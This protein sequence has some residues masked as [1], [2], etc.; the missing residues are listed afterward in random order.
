LKRDLRGT[1][2][3]NDRLKAVLDEL[4]TMLFMVRTTAPDGQKAALIVP[5]IAYRIEHLEED[6]QARIWWEFSEAARNV[7]RSSESYAAI[8]RGILLAFDSRYAVTLYELGC[9][10][11]GRR[12]P[13]WE[14]TVE[15]LREVMGV[16][17]GK[18]RDWTGIRQ[19]VL[20]PACAEVNQIALFDVSYRTI[21]GL[22]RKVT[23][24]KLWFTVKSGHAAE[25]ADREMAASRVGRKARRT[26][27]AEVV[28]KFELPRSERDT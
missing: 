3:S 13:Y 26:G 18:Y 7:M 27:Q 9:L 1:H 12:Y 8:N 4:Q 16:P 2:E 22:R 28:T 14:G 21:E 25:V 17:A 10:L 20:E 6:D 5:V 24:I 23:T 11:V 15:Q 19:K